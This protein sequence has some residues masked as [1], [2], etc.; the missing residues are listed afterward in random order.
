[1]PR[2]VSRRTGVSPHD[3]P[4]RHLS[5][6]SLPGATDLR[7]LRADF[8]GHAVPATPP[9][10]SGPAATTSRGCVP[11][12]PIALPAHRRQAS[13][14]GL[15]EPQHLLQL[16]EGRLDHPLPHRVQLPALLRPELSRPPSLRR[17]V[18]GDPASGCRRHLLVVPHPADG[19]RQ[20]P[21]FFPVPMFGGRSGA[22]S[23]SSKIFPG[24]ERHG[25]GNLL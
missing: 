7:P 3:R 8:G 14:R 5:P 11:R 24:L 18:L 21:A 1:V 15:P 12:T 4:R 19:A 22:F 2:A 25:V 13:R 16:A 23:M 9:S 20:R 6:P 17:Q 10:P